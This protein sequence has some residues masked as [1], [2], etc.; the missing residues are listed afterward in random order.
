MRCPIC[1]KEM[2][3]DDNIVIFRGE[4]IKM[5]E[6]GQE[7]IKAM[8]QEKHEAIHQG[9]EAETIVDLPADL[10]AVYNVL[11][12]TEK[13]FEVLD[14]FLEKA[15]VALA[16]QVKYEKIIDD[17]AEEIADC[18]EIGLYCDGCQDFEDE[19]EDCLG[20][21]SDKCRVHIGKYY[22]QRAGLGG[23]E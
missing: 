20:T 16:N 13:Q 11:H 3:V 14:T 4:N 19:N 18:A 5:A 9:K 22:K 21:S 17:M 23:E 1:G 7:S 2:G 15:L 6:R 10:Q 12:L 8:S